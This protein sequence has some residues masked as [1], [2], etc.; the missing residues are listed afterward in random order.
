[1]ATTVTNTN[2]I[3]IT[4]GTMSNGARATIYPGQIT[5]SF[6]VTAVG[7]ISTAANSAFTITDNSSAGNVLIKGS[8]VATVNTIADPI[9]YYFNPPVTWADWK[10]NTLGTAGDTVLVWIK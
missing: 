1:M 5:R 8:G 6:K 7:F 10:L 3:T 2:P 4:G 9:M